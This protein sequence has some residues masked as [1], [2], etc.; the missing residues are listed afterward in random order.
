MRSSVS[1]IID[2]IY[3][4][5][6]RLFFLIFNGLHRFSEACVIF[7][8]SPIGDNNVLKFH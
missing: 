5:V 2:C 7:L 1:S 6:T 3:K 8:E 4:V